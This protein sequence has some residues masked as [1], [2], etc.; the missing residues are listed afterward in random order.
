MKISIVT[1]TFNSA[2]YLEETILSVVT[3]KNIDLEYLVVDGGSSDSSSD[4]LSKYSSQIQWSCSERDNGQ[5]DAINKGF[6]KSTGEIMGWLNSSDLYLPWTLKVVEEIFTRF[7]EV[8]WI[9]SLQKTVLT[10]KGSHAS[11]N[12]HGFSAN[13]FAQ[14]LLG[15]DTNAN[16]IQ[17]ETCFWRRSLWEKIG[18]Q[19]SSQYRYAGDFWLWSQ[20]FQH[21]KCTGV[22]APLAVFRFHEDQRSGHEKYLSEV[23]EIL[24]EIESPGKRHLYKSGCQ[25][26]QP[27]W[28][29]SPS[30]GGHTDWHMV[31]YFDDWYLDLVTFWD[32]FLDSIKW[33]LANLSYLP[34]SLLKFIK[35]GCKRVR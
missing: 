32:E 8:E 17:Q 19:I 9:S 6:N 12:I 2:S 28:R 14:G 10:S 18:G 3:Q 7:P 29:F 20:F 35:R 33:K 5:Y 16:F 11:W 26:I 30:E 15:S 21:A 23:T 25:N 13:K 27:R 22:D 24:Q 31:K 4:V 34:I 1:P